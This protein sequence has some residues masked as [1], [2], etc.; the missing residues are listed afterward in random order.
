MTSGTGA[1]GRDRTAEITEQHNRW[2]RL[3]NGMLPLQ[4]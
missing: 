2:L 4:T 3:Q 1:G